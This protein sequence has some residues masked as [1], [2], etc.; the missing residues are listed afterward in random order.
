MRTVE[1]IRT[2]RLAQLIEEAGSV[3]AV[4]ERMEKSL[5]QISQLKTMAAHSTS[6]R[7]RVIGSDLAR[8][9][10]EKFAKPRGWMDNDPAK[11]APAPRLPFAD[12]GPFEAQ[13]ITLYRRL[14]ADQQHDVLVEVNKLADTGGTGAPSPSNPFPAP[15]TGPERR[16]SRAGEKTS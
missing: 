1:E 4:A 11:D 3:Q 2:A 15:Y 13:L 6:G 7:P 14:S 10:E 5:S 9:F 12:L 8:E 16:V